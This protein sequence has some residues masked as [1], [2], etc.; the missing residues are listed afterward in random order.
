MA[1]QKEKYKAQIKVL[2][3]LIREVSDKGVSIQAQEAR[4]KQ[5]VEQFFKRE[6]SQV[7]AK[8][9]STAAAINYYKNMSNT[10]VVTPQFMDRKK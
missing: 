2:Q 10:G 9:K 5:L 7:S 1:S 4:N 3:N 8:R 6:K